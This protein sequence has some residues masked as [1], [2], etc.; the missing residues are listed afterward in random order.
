MFSRVR[1]IDKLFFTKH[2]TVMVKSGVTVVDAL[3]NLTAQKNQYFSKVIKGVLRNVENGVG[4]C[5]ALAKYPSVFDSFYCNLIKVGEMSGVLDQI[6]E[7]LTKQLEKERSLSAKIRGAMLYPMIVLSLAV[8]IGSGILLFVLPQMVNLFK[9]LDITLPLS[10]RILLFLGETA[11]NYGLYIV[12]GII[13]FIVSVWRLLK[14]KFI[15]N[16]CDTVVLRIP[17]VGDFLLNAQLT[18][19]FRNLG[20]M[21]GNGLTVN[22]ALSIQA[23][24][25][26]NAVFKKYS[27][28][29]KQTVENGRPI[30]NE[31]ENRK[32][33]LMPPIVGKMVKVGEKTGTLSETFI[34]LGNFFEEEL[35]TLAKNFP[36]KLEPVMLILIGL[37][38]AFVALAVISPIYG[39]TGGIK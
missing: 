9:S 19:M 5:E 28:S 24:I 3:E 7:C 22:D 20:L 34:Y 12:L 10:T 1:F 27:K 23:D 32:F 36:N 4:L 35:D 30:F 38:V 16:I 21:L 6:L 2:M 15:Q 14:I 37:V 17:I 31:L 18:S 11:K 26:S 39:L 33:H 13:F 29:L 8:V 25:S